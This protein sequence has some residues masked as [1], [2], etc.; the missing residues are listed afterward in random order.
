M[1]RAAIIHLLTELGPVLIFFIVGELYDFFTAVSI[2]V[3]A[4]VLALAASWLYERRL[5][6]LAI[7]STIFVVV[8]GLITLIYKAPDAIIVAD[9]IYYFL[10]AGTIGYGLLKRQLFLKWLFDRTFAMHDEGW[11]ILSL[12]WLYVCS[13]AGVANE[14]VRLLCTPEFWIDYRFVKILIIAGFGMYQ[15]RLSRQYR[16][17]EESNQWGV[18]ITKLKE[19]PPANS[20]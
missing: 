2:L 13:V 14:I 6:F 8:S 15:F 12:R 4:T 19:V 3:V 5:P 18:R 7:L 20:N 1:T 10:I 17:A 9:T 16:I 11:Y